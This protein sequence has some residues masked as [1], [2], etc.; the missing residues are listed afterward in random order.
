MRRALNKLQER[1]FDDDCGV[2]DFEMTDDIVILEE[3]PE[4]GRLFQDRFA[5][6]AKDDNLKLTFQNGRSLRLH[7]TQYK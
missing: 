7:L 3:N 1:R 5:C 2:S 6:K 4:S